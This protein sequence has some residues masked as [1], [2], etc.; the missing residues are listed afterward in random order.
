MLSTAVMINAEEELPIDLDKEGI[1]ADM[2][3]QE[4]VNQGGLPLTKSQKIKLAEYLVKVKN[5]KQ[6]LIK[7]VA[8]LEERIKLERNASDEV[9]QKAEEEIQALEEEIEVKDEKIKMLEE[10]L[11]EEKNKNTG[12]KLK[13]KAKYFGYGNISGAGFMLLFVFLAGGN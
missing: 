3:I 4:F 11:E 6:K 13:E 10:L 5:D 9:I 12:V 8:K 7:K 2:T 1:P